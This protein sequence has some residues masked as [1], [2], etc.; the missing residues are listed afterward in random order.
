MDENK[1]KEVSK[2]GNSYMKDDKNFYQRREP[3]GYR[4]ENI[5]KEDKG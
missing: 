5:G 1:D 4:N 3:D 2:E